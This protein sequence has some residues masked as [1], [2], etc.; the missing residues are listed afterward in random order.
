MRKKILLCTVLV[1]VLAAAVTVQRN[2]PV[3]EAAK[4]R[5]A[6]NAYIYY[7]QDPPAQYDGT[8]T[9]TVVICPYG[10]HTGELAL[11]Y[12]G[13]P[14]G[15]WGHYYYV[16]PKIRDSGLSVGTPVTCWYKNP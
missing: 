13:D 11:E 14:G 2:T 6:N 12:E 7:L 3:V 8:F 5:V 1:I 16:S 9:A 10:K 15:T 4:P